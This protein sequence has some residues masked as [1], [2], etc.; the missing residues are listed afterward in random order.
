[1]S[2]RVV[3]SSIE[4]VSYL[5]AKCKNN[6]I[7]LCTWIQVEDERTRFLNSHNFFFY[8]GWMHLLRTKDC[9]TYSFS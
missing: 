1:M 2:S 7:V 3:L 4:L 9:C 5:V 6:V 8:Y